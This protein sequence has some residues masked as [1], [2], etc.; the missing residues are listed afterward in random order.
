MTNKKAI[1]YLSYTGMLEPLGRSQVLSYLFKLSA[2]YNFTVVSFEKKEDLKNFKLVEGL[3][4]ECKKH[5]IT[6][7]PQKYHKSPR[8]LA[9]LWDMLLMFYIALKQ[10]KCSSFSLVH[11][12]SYVA[13][14]IALLLK[15]VINVQFLFDMRALWVEELL[16]AGS[17]RRDSLLTRALYVLERKLLVNSYHI[18]SL[19]RA[20]IPYLK[21]KYPEL[22]VSKFTVIPTCVDLDK[23]NLNGNERNSLKCL[24]TAG[25]VVSGRYQLDQLLVIFKDFKEEDRD[26]KFKIISR[27]DVEVVKDRAK[28][29]NFD[30]NYMEMYSAG[31]ESICAELSHLDFAFVLFTPGESTLGTSPTRIGEFLAMGIPVVVNSDV[32]DTANIIKENEIG[33][34]IDGHISSSELLAKMRQL[35]ADRLLANRC[36]SV[37]KDIFSVNTGAMEYQK[38]YSKCNS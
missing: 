37:A 38:A 14:G 22:D 28:S 36:R 29:L 4:S 3:K 27:D 20:A 9:T 32:G 17:I 21:K 8:L 7:L 23:F 6:W 2:K 24:G 12:R 31:R 26:I 11:G 16:E 35:K 15:K 10:H 5:G 25:T 18:I 19:T 1:L 33:V 13:S 30:F 34:V